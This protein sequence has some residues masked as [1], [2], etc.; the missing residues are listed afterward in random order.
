MYN[1]MLLQYQEGV[2]LITAQLA[3]R[4]KARLQKEEAEQ[5]AKKK[6]VMNADDT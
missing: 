4:E 1:L 2:M 5:E 6:E 3:E